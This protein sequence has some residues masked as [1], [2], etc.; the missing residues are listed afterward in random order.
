MVT[1]DQRLLLDTHTLLWWLD[2]G[3]L[4]SEE[5]R[6]L[7]ALKENLVFVSVVSAWEIA[8]KRSIGK[9]VCPGNLKQELENHAFELLAVSLE[10]TEV[11]AEL[12]FH[13]RDPFDRMLVAQAKRENLTILT[14]DIHIPRYGVKCITS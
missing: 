1:S 3:K 11:L 12:P 5:A 8:I 6:E 13:H 2:G 14:R 10:D 7:I 4:I 9:I